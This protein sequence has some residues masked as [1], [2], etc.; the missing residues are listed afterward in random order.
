MKR[1]WLILI[2]VLCL[3]I[4]ASADI[5][6][7][8]T[9][10]PS[11]HI[12]NSNGN[13]YVCIDPN[14]QASN[15]IDQ[16]GTYHYSSGGV[17]AGYVAM[18]A[19]YQ[20]NG[21]SHSL[22]VAIRSFTNAH[23]KLNAQGGEFIYSPTGYQDEGSI[24][25]GSGGIKDYY[26][27]GLCAA[28]LC[29]YRCDGTAGKQFVLDNASGSNQTSSA[30]SGEVSFD[31]INS[32]VNETMN[33]YRKTVRVKM[34][35]GDG[36]SVPTSCSASN[37]F[38]CS[39]SNTSGSEFDVTVG[40]GAL[41]TSTSTRVTFSVR[42]NKAGGIDLNESSVNVYQ[43]T[44]SRTE[45]HSSGKFY[46]FQRFLTLN[47]EVPQQNGGITIPVKTKCDNNMSVIDL[48]K[49]GCCDTIDTS[50]ISKNSE[51]EKQY[52][53]MCGDIIHFE[54]D[55]GA[56]SC[57][58]TS[59]KAFSNSWI[60]QVDY[61]TLMQKM[62]N[63]DYGNLSKY[64]DRFYNG[65]SNGYCTSYATEY[66]DIY[67]P[68]TAASTSGRY[69]VFDNYNDISC[70]SSTCL[71]QPYVV[72]M[73][74]GIFHTNYN[75]WLNNYNSALTAERDAYNTWQQTVKSIKPA[76]NAY[77][78]AEAAYQ[79]CLNYGCPGD[80][81]WSTCSYKRDS[82]GQILRE[83]NGDPIIDY[84]TCQR[85]DL[86]SQRK[87]EMDTAYTNW[88]ELVNK[89]PAEHESFKAR[90]LERL[91]LQAA[92]N[93][94]D[95][96]HNSYQN[97]WSYNLKTN[98]NFMYAQKA[99]T[100][101]GLLSSTVPM[102]ISTSAVKYWPNVSSMGSVTSLADD[103]SGKKGSGL[104]GVQKSTMYIT[105]KHSISG[106]KIIDEEG[107]TASYSFSEDCSSDAC[108]RYDYTSLAYTVVKSSG[109]ASDP[110]GNVSSND[111]GSILF[112][113]PKVYTYSLMP[114]GAYKTLEYQSDSYMMDTGNS[115]PVGYVYN[116]EL[117][118]YEGQYTTSFEINSFNTNV[119]KSL[120]EYLS[121]HNIGNISDLT[122]SECNYCNI[123]YA[124][125]RKCEE[126][127]D[128]DPLKPSFYFR[129]ISLSD[130]NNGIENRD[131]NWSDEKG[132]AAVKEIQSLSGVKT[133]GDLGNTYIAIAD[134]NDNIKTT[135]DE[136]TYLADS[137]GLNYTYDEDHLE[138][139][140]TL[141]SKDMQMIKKNSRSNDFN[142]TNMTFC[143]SKDEEIGSSVKGDDVAYCFV[144]NKYQ[145]ECVSTFV[146][147][148]SDEDITDNTRR[149]K[150]KY[151][152][153]NPNTGSGSFK[154]GTMDTLKSE[155]EKVN[156][157]YMDYPEADTSGYPDPL[158]AKAWLA[159][160][161]NW[162]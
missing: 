107:N 31:I 100:S 82:K 123:E 88:Q 146:S 57:E 13:R 22:S 117:S 91:A 58:D 127:D 38:S 114:S 133:V 2:F 96:Y 12:Y 97:N 138:Y 4:I 59:Y 43:C 129:S 99:S 80:I 147:A 28:G 67:F 11:D 29:D 81:I 78:S 151:Y 65:G 34:T 83:K 93:E 16:I 144:C 49:S 111:I 63:G 60:K 64:A 87:S 95:S 148:Y 32:N 135:N 53:K 1:F 27:A 10:V 52:L 26:C 98:M 18:M 44:R 8:I 132:N 50:K 92:K 66:N 37:G 61:E 119:Q 154:L 137:K 85:T 159:T 21:D 112:Y 128:S 69:F 30:S 35:N 73:A 102:E 136:K 160:Y 134:G 121:K 149:N 23:N 19:Y 39:I 20:V 105:N 131:S 155:F 42:G 104:T 125:S 33:P 45:C 5:S 106:V 6:L 62:N 36:F 113:R 86:T 54:N 7:D 90:I 108:Q 152:F 118:A 103:N 51:E 110:Y 126:C 75:M 55:C 139:S 71:R 15:F 70:T 130:V 56:N 79:S 89:E 156:K 76:Y 145:K 94:C 153:Y 157:G 25:N 48:I 161:K 77:K 141:T 158:F 17:E 143:T 162:P 68:A 115:L 41:G 142:Y 84:S 101:S 109:S 24:L 9:S 14:L 116:I 3:P 124:F 46:T 74:H 40:I 150:W 120:E 72:G 122:S 47:A 140:I